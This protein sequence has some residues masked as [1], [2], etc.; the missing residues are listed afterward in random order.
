MYQNEMGLKWLESKQ[1]ALQHIQNLGPKEL[2]I[3]YGKFYK[4]E[5]NFQIEELGTLK[6]M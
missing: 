3:N 6:H 2:N 4:T 5:Q 1:I